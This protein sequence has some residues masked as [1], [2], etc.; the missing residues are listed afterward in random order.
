VKELA[1]FLERNGLTWYKTNI[2]CLG[3]YSIE[4]EERENRENI[5]KLKKKQYVAWKKESSRIGGK[6]REKSFVAVL[7]VANV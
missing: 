4:K 6:K 1:F 7:K 2:S 3:V 5:S